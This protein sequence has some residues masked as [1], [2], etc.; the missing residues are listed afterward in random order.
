MREELKERIL[1]FKNSRKTFAFVVPTSKRTFTFFIVDF[2][3]HK[4]K[5]LLKGEASV[6]E[7][8][9]DFAF[10]LLQIEYKTVSD[11]EIFDHKTASFQNWHYYKTVDDLIDCLIAKGIN[12]NT[13]L[14]V[15][16]W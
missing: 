2:I 6:E 11:I 14:H 1:M 16:L 13:R 4:E 3:F 7:F 12:M 10:I 5:E 8:F 15:S 9:D